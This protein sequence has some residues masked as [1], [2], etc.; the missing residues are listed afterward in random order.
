MSKLGISR[1]TSAVDL[2]TNLELLAE[3]EAASAA[4]EKLQRGLNKDDRLNSQNKEL[5]QAAQ[6]V[7]AIEDKMTDSTVS[8]KLRALK[9]TRW[10]EL[11]EKFPAREDSDLD[12]RFGVNVDAFFEVAIPECV[13]EITDKKTGKKIEFDPATE[14]A[15]L[16]DD[17]SDGQYAEFIGATLALNRGATAVPFSRVASAVTQS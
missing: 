6:A 16:A 1:A 14:W 7:R 3:H 4:L 11:E 9:R 8:V 17:M 10:A 15:P 13:V 12:K 5:K 2:V